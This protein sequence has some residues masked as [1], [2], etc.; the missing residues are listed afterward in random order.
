MGTVSHLLLVRALLP[1]TKHPCPCVTTRE[2]TG[3]VLPWKLVASSLSFSEMF[4]R[5]TINF[6]S[7]EDKAGSRHP[8]RDKWCHLKMRSY[9]CRILNRAVLRRA[10]M[11]CARLGWMWMCLCHISGCSWEVVVLSSESSFHSSSCSF[12]VAEGSWNRLQRP[13][14]STGAIPGFNSRAFLSQT[15]CYDKDKTFAYSPFSKQSSFSWLSPRA[16]TRDLPVLPSGCLTI[17][18]ESIRLPQLWSSSRQRATRRSGISLI[19]SNN[20]LLVHS[21]FSYDFNGTAFPVGFFCMEKA[22]SQ[23]TF[24]AS[25]IWRGCRCTLLILEVSFSLFQGEHHCQ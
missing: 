17:G 20:G 9:D 8:P 19:S 13:G 24:V 6:P 14:W 10:G 1:L 3:A 7:A 12:A 2:F 23:G 5:A 4:S 11:E 22:W 15:L 18:S 16:Q 25:K 21:W